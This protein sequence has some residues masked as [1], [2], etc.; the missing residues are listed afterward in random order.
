M[1]RR[2]VGGAPADDERAVSPPLG[3]ALLAGMTVVLVV[4]LAGL[5]FGI[6]GDQPEPA[7]MGAFDD[8]YVA[9]G[10]GN[11][12]NRP[13]VNFSYRGGDTIPGSKLY[14]H[15]SDGNSV[16]WEDV[17]T[18]GPTVES[19]EYLHIDGYES[20][21]AL[22]HA[23]KGETYRLVWQ[24]DGRAFVLAELTVPTAAEGPAAS[25]C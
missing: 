25:H 17:W 8:G 24:G 16:A 9:D 4:I 10:Q 2:T 15:D 1:N 14:V 19:G 3:I 20:D 5:A 7:P 21:K 18:G 11:T 22:N 12:N 13:Y 23:C 6:A